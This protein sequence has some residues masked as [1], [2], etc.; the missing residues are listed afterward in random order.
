[1][2]DQQVDDA[3]KHQRESRDSVTS[4]EAYD[5][6]CSTT[7]IGPLKEARGSNILLRQGHRLR[8]DAT[9]KQQRDPSNRKTK[10]ETD[11]DEVGAC[12]SAGRRCAR[13]KQASRH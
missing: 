12:N 10:T 9:A 13:D 6:V 11:F 2:S 1:M 7:L 5:A 4:Q 3:I 8:C